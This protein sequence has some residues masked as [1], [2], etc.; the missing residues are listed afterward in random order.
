MKAVRLFPLLSILILAACSGIGDDKPIGSILITATH[1]CDV[2]LFDD[3]GRQ[4]A[5][6]HYEVGKAPIVVSMKRS[7]LYIVQAKFIGSGLAPAH[8][9]I[10]EP[11]AYP[12]G[13]F[14]Y[15]IEF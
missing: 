3:S 11:I 13:S 12:G 9:T 15:C 4:T 1:D 8:T 7:G 5:R 2:R 10:N 14:D 6:E